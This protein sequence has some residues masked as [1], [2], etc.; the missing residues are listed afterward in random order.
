M[1]L[2]KWL[3]IRRLT[4]YRWLERGLP[5]VKLGRDFLFPYKECQEWVKDYWG[6]CP[7]L[8]DKLRRE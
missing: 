6:E 2:C 3:G 8:Q 7:D 1:D 4:V 5:S